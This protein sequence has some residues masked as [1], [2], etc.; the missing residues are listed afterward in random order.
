MPITYL[1]RTADVVNVSI[2][3]IFR[4]VKKSECGKDAYLSAISS[5]TV[6]T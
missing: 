5:G 6:R 1:F 3:P 4:L 2:Q